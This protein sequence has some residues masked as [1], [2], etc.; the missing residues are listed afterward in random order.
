DEPL[1]STV[2]RLHPPFDPV[3]DV[4]PL[5]DY[6]AVDGLLTGYT[7]EASMYLRDA[8]IRYQEPH[9]NFV[10]TGSLSEAIDELVSI[11][12]TSIMVALLENREGVN[13]YGLGF[14]ELE[15]IAHIT[16]AVQQILDALSA[17]SSKQPKARFTVDPNYGYL[18]LLEENEHSATIRILFSSLQL[19]LKRA[20]THIRKQLANL[21]RIWTNDDE[22]TLGSVN[23][24]VTDVRQYYGMVSPRTELAR[25]V[26]RSDYGQR[27]AWV[28]PQAHRDLLAIFPAGEMPAQFPYRAPSHGL[29]GV[30]PTIKEPERPITPVSAAPSAAAGNNGFQSPGAGTVRFQ[31]PPPPPISALLR[32]TAVKSLPGAGRIP[33]MHN[34]GQPISNTGGP[35]M[36]HT[37]A[38][39]LQLKATYTTTKTNDPLL[40]QTPVNSS[41]VPPSGPPNAPSP[42][43][44]SNYPGSS[45]GGGGG[46]G[47]GGG[48]HP[49]GGG[50]GPGGGSPSG[51]GPGGGNPGGNP[52]GHPGGPP[53]GAGGGGGG[54][55]G[56][57]PMANAG[58][59]PA[60]ADQWQLNHKLQLSVIPSWDGGPITVFDYVI[61]MD[62]LAL[63]SPR[64]AV[65]IAQLASS[66]FTGRAENWWIALPPA[67]QEFYSAGWVYLLDGIRRQFLTPRWLLDRTKEF[68]Q[69][70]FR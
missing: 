70:R 14:V 65:G 54:G 23:S 69:M 6:G 33:N 50:G 60:G 47:Q 36:M 31:T 61:R 58:S 22:G 16:V 32:P 44:P 19:R 53:G 25:L 48:R 3:Q 13:Y 67:A 56:P 59:D 27:A 37:A 24:T 55:N 63:L 45:G 30:I 12:A 35:S 4:D 5:M 40:V 51:G 43:H 29:E 20:D 38:L 9:N 2:L 41:K 49:T 8:I 7:A 21:R 28:D 1:S 10:W 26:A 11:D 17:F 15:S 18:C 52:G 64:M 34:V 66:K 46:W 62:A 39:G 42:N 57:G 68:E